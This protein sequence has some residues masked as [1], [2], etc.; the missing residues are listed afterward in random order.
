MR[1]GHSITLTSQ[2]VPNVVLHYTAW[3]HLAAQ[4]SRGGCVALI[5]AAP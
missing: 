3:L 5:A 4:P 1:D 2:A